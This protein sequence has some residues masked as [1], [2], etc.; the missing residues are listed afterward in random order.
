MA[1]YQII[2]I[3]LPPLDDDQIEE[4][5]KK[6]VIFGPSPLEKAF[7]VFNRIKKIELILEE[8]YNDRPTS[9]KS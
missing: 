9:E 7:D 5:K 1:G 6:L 3:N 4:I 2:R 8:R